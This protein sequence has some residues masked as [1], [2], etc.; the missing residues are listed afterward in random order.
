M[1]DPAGIKFPV[2]RP[3][4]S[5][6]ELRNVTEAVRSGWVSSTGKFVR[7]FEE[8][9]SRYLGGG[10]SVC[11]SNGTTALHLAFK[12]LR[13][14]KGDRV[15]VPNLTFASPANAAI[16]EGAEPVLADVHPGNWGLDPER[17]EGLIDERTK[18]IVVVHLYGNPCDLRPIL[19]VAR[20]HDLYVIEDCAEALGA[21]YH[22]K[23]V[24]LAGDISCFSFYGNKIITT[25][26]GGMVVTENERWE[27][28]VRVLRDHGMRPSKRYWHDEVGYNYR[29]TNLQAALGVAQLERVQGF[30]EKKRRMAAWYARGLRHP[31]ILQTHPDP[32]WG[33]SVFWLYSIQCAFEARGKNRRE[34]LAA[35]LSSQGIETRPFFYPLNE[36]P[37]YAALKAD[38]DLSVSQRLSQGG[39]SLPSGVDLTRDDVRKVSEA[40]VAGLGE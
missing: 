16:Y 9:F 27:D 14:G 4:L 20:A 24:G 2:Y 11:T 36:M 13:I 38:K 22:G 19:K 18:A 15:I 39:V 21:E 33:K 1:S 5:G 37:P 32:E 23:K 31:R 26:E 40:V 29:M 25:G 7:Q 12:A 6:K 17:L 3:N 10:R 28:R 35:G 30:V 34:E 8:D